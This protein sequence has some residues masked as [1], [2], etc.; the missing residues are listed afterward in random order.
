MHLIRSFW[1]PILWSFVVLSLSAISG[2]IVDEVPIM[3]IHNI[4]KVGHFG[5][6]F[7][8]TYLL[9]FDFRRYKNQALEKWQVVLLSLFVAIIY[10]GSMEIL[11]LL[12]NLHRSTD[13]RDFIANSSGAIMAVV[14]FKTINIVLN[15]LLLIF[16]RP[17][18]NYSL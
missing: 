8:L 16:I 5:M 2:N 18:K 17:K 3:H 6:Y 12:P 11:Q 10:G 14:L 9:L 13:I 1:R 4:D 15:K 7:I